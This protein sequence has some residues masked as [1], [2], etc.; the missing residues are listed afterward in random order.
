MSLVT[1]HASKG[2]EWPIVVPINTMTSGNDV[3]DPIIAGDAKTI[4]LPIFGVAP[5]GYD[6][7]KAAEVAER[8]RE[9]VRLWYV[10]PTRARELLI[11]PKLDVAPARSSWNALMDFDL[12]GLPVIAIDHHPQGFQT[13]DGDPENSQMR[14]TFAAEAA[15]VVAATTRLRWVAPSRD[16]DVKGPLQV[17]AE[18]QIVVAA[19]DRP[20]FDVTIAVQ[21]GRERGLVIHKLFEE[22]LTGETAN[23]LTAL[24]A[25]AEDLVRS[26]G[27]KPGAGAMSGLFPEEM[28]GTVAKTLQLPEIAALSPRLMAEFPVYGFRKEDSVKLATCGIVDALYIGENGRPELVIDWKSDVVPNAAASDHYRSQVR[29]YLEVTGIPEGLVVFVTTGDVLRVSAP[30]LKL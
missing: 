27:R 30:T 22:V 13:I 29:Q 14:E 5:A 23:D 1:M 3:R 12:D 20:E 7:A 26:I 6:D 21:G 11:L 17:A 19:E 2:L 16:E 15:R 25:R 10:A 18:P 28:A 9:R 24:T 4:F 8:E